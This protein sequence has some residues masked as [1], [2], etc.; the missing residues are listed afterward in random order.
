[1]WILFD[2]SI[3]SKPDAD[4]FFAF[5]GIRDNVMP[6]TVDRILREVGELKRDVPEP[7]H[8]SISRH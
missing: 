6:C 2:W 3:N 4:S 8:D 1:M 5:R 7:I